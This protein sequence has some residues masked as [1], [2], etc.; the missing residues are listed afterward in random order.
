M[1][2][3]QRDQ[4]AA[5]EQARNMVEGKG[6]FGWLTRLF[7]GKA[8]SAGFAADLNEA[9]AHLNHA[10]W[11]QQLLATGQPARAIVRELRDTGALVNFNPV[12]TLELDVHADGHPAWPATVTTP[13]SKIAVPRV[14]DVVEVRYNPENQQEVALLH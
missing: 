6:L 3:L 14:N 9:E 8:T 12:V 4:R 5:L 2:N 7:L 11:Q 13:V 10:K 1:S